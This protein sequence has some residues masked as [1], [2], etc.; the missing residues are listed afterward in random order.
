MI[1]SDFPGG[2][3]GDAVNAFTGEGLTAQQK[4][5]QEYIRS[6]G[7]FAPSIVCLEHG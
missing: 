1:R 6:V 5:A 4:E 3:E 7:P 2:W